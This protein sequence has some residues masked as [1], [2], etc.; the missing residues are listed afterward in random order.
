M[1]PILFVVGLPIGHPDDLSPRALE[2]LRTADLLICESRKV[3]ST[4]Y[5]RHE[6]EFPREAYRELNQHTRSAE[7]RELL[8]AVLNASRTVLIS[9]AGMP[10]L[11]DPGANVVRQARN[12]GIRVQVIP[13]PTALT[14]ALAVAGLGGH[15]FYFAGFAPRKTPERQK[16]LERLFHRNLRGQPVVLYETPYRLHKILDEIAKTAPPAF[17]LFLAVDLTT[18]KEFTLDVPVRNIQAEAGRVPKGNPV[19]ILYEERGSVR[20]DS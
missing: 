8:D 13:G 6:L 11:E 9:D 3:A 12:M 17:H 15:G 10:V 18:E 4:L 14:A 2:A 1:K 20:F 16:F 7:L 5:R 19:L